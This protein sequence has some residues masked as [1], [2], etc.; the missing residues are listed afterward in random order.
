MRP[1]AANSS[2]APQRV[3][4]RRNRRRTRKELNARAQ[5]VQ[6]RIEQTVAARSEA[7]ADPEMVGR[8]A[9]LVYHQDGDLTPSRGDDAYL[10]AEVDGSLPAL[11][12]QKRDAGISFVESAS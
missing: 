2:S 12:G 11:H 4:P 8:S 7:W 10:H 6:D 5:R 3:E 1:A 9:N